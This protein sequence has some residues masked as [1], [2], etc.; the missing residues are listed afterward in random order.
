[1]LY[2]G[3]A[4]LKKDQNGT[5]DYKLGADG[6]KEADKSYSV[7]EKELFYSY[8]RCGVDQTTGKIDPNLDIDKAANVTY[9]SNANYIIFRDIKLTSN[10]TPL[11]FS[12]NMIGA[13]ETG[14]STLW[15]NDSS[16][17]DY[18][19]ATDFAEDVTKPVISDVVIEQSEKINVGETMGVGFFATFI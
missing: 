14:K 11:M 6:I 7:H 9:A 13:K 10:W 19:K 2:G 18:S 16:V 15:K 3:D 12:G 8:G 4:D 5:E 17:D 1:M